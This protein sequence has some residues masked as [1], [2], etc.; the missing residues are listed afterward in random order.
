MSSEIGPVAL[1][2]DGGRTMFGRG[3]EDKEYSEKVS[4]LIDSEVSK[5]MNEAFSKAKNIL[6]EKKEVLDAIAKKLI[7]VET[8]EQNEYNDLIKSFGINPKTLENIA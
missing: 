2:S 1:E 8:L 7:E 5:I 6:T 3:V 4:S